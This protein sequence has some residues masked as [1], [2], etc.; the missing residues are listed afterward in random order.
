MRKKAVILLAFIIIL[1]C[2]CSQDSYRETEGDG[3]PAVSGEDGGKANDDR[4]ENSGEIITVTWA[5]LDYN[6]ENAVR[7]EEDVNRRLEE[8]GYP[9]RLKCIL[10]DDI[11]TY[12]EFI[13]SVDADIVMTGVKTRTADNCSLGFQ[14]AYY[15]I[16]EGKYLR[17]D[18]YLEG[19]RLYDFIPE[20]DWKSVEYNG[21]IYCVPNTA[22][23]ADCGKAIL[24][25]KDRFTAEEVASF[26]GSWESM[27]EL[28][29]DDRILLCSDNAWLPALGINTGWA[30]NTYEEAGTLKNL[31]DNEEHLA[32]IRLVHG[33]YKE[34]RLYQ[35]PAFELLPDELEKPDWSV[36]VLPYQSKNEY[37]EQDYYIVRYKC[38]VG[39][40]MAYSV[41]I[42]AGSEHPQEAFELLQLLMT[43]STYGNL[44]LFGDE[45][46]EEDGYAVSKTTGDRVYMF[47]L[48]LMWGIN[49]GTL[50]GSDDANTFNDPDERKS[51]CNEWVTYYEHP[52]LNYPEEVARLEELNIT[53][54]D[55]ITEDNEETFEFKLK[56]LKKES[57]KVFESINDRSGNDGKE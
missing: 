14:P 15:A 10:Y 43:D 54:G 56:K 35:G 20:T 55:L 37:D 36:A 4:K 27:S 42:T 46:E 21:G 24:F 57:D 2:A 51:F 39:D 12:N 23:P 44:V 25:K 26:D 5:T 34:N 48:R 19:S 41:A 28:L 53:Y 8:E 9:F 16:Q 17:L 52:E 3:S 11:A 50:K 45:I 32:W 6:G 7:I 47:T 31:M 22:C 29:G 33:L 49:D 18:D 13:G 1:L 40:H 38:G 30:G